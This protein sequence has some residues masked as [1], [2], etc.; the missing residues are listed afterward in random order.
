MAAPKEFKSSSSISLESVKII[1]ESIGV[2]NIS[3]DAA[4]LIA[5]DISYRMK[6]IVQVHYFVKINFIF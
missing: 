6:M 2:S 1:A 4:K 5:D 3:D